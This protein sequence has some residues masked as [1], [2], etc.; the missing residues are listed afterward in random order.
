[1][2]HVAEADDGAG[3]ENRRRQAKKAAEADI[4]KPVAG[5]HR[6]TDDQQHRKRRKQI[7]VAPK[8]RDQYQLSAAF[9]A[10]TWQEQGLSKR[11]EEGGSEQ[12]DSREEKYL[13]VDRSRHGNHC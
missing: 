11:R 13:S 8:D 1:L 9:S 2:K 3:N 4:S 10:T 7:E 6:E 5:A 12:A